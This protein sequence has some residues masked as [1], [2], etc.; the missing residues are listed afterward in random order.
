[1]FTGFGKNVL[2]A[3]HG[4]TF[5]ILLFFKYTILCFQHYLIYCFNILFHYG[6]YND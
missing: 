1:M 5:L 3:A 4:C 6:R 2:E